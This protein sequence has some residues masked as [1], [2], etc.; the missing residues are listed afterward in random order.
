MAVV[1]PYN[2]TPHDGTGTTVSYQKQTV[3]SDGTRT[4]VGSPVVYTVTNL[5]YQLSSQSSGDNDIDVTHL[6]LAYGDEVLTQPRPLV[7]T[8]SGETG[9]EFQIDFIGTEVLD[10][11]QEGTLT[12]NGPVSWTG[13]AKVTSS[14]CTLQPNDVVRGSITFAVERKALTVPAPFETRLGSG[15]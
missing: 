9:R 6:G 7:G 1:N 15:D 2:P 10:D 13:E 14:S 4:D 5:Q 3:N 11:D 12:I 8:T